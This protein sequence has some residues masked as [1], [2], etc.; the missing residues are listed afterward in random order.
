MNVKITHML[1]CSTFFPH[2]IQFLKMGFQ[3][4][5]FYRHCGLYRRK[6][7]MNLQLYPNY[8]WKKALIWNMCEICLCLLHL[9][10][11]SICHYNFI[12]MKGLLKLLL[13][14]CSLPSCHYSRLWVIDREISTQ[15]YSLLSLWLD[16]CPRR[17]QEWSGD[18]TTTVSESL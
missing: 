6:V 5:T 15:I 7:F 2:I 14:N 8:K 3:C 18:L 1:L 12:T 13:Y 10:N 9:S 17:G 4:P 16:H 11:T